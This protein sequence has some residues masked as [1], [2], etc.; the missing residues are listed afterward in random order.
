MKH[1][2]LRIAWSVAWGIVA[3]LLVA[4]WVR[5]MSFSDAASAPLPGGHGISVESFSSRTD[6]QLW[7]P[8]RLPWHAQTYALSELKALGVEEPPFEGL[9]F[10]FYPR[11][12]YCGLTLPY[13]FNV[14]FA[15][16]AA[17]FP[18]IRLE[19]FRHFS[20][21]TLLIAPTLVAV[22][23]GVVVWLQGSSN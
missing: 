16:G 12:A 5:S 9:G 13:W 8:N 1:R 4:S 14:L 7:Y 20:L 22:L 19:W 10:S 15:F 11:N 21:R 18:W 23:L 17:V 3:L 6:I 2:K